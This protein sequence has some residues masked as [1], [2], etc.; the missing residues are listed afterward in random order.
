MIHVVAHNSPLYWQSVRLRDEVLRQPLNLQFSKE[1]LSNEDDSYHIVKIN[2][3]QVIGCLVLKPLSKTGI[4]MRQVAVHPDFQKRGIGK[5]LVH[6][7]EQ[8]AGENG[9]QS[10]EL[11]ARDL[12]IPFYKQLDYKPVGNWFTEVG[13]EHRK[14]MKQL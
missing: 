14:M 5:E 9:F 1:E 13:I 10:M 6:F 12:A 2:S 8:F 11:H 4:K 3:E 7:S